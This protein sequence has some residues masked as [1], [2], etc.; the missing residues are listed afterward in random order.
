METSKSNAPAPI[1]LVALWNRFAKSLKRTWILVLAL[2]VLFAGVNY[3]RARRS[4]AQSIPRCSLPS[5]TGSG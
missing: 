5:L 4:Y 3:V 2:A 1:D